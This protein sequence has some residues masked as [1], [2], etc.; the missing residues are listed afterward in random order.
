[1]GDDA[2]ELVALASASCEDSSVAAAAAAAAA[3]DAEVDLDDEDD[4]ES[5]FLLAR[6]ALLRGGMA[7]NGC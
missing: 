1:M 5:S 2:R 6:V 4:L 7:N 3:K